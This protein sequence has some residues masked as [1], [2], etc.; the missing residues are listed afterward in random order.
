MKEFQSQCVAQ[1]QYVVDVTLPVAYILLPSKD[2]F[3]SIY[4]R[5][6]LS[7]CTLI[8]VMT[9]HDSGHCLFNLFNH[10]CLFNKIIRYELDLLFV[11]DL[12]HAIS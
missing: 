5:Q 9:L 1:C 6:E 7:G 11:T 2:A 12:Q 3:Q 8:I 4:N 10:I